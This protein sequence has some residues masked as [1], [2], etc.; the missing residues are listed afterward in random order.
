MFIKVSAGVI[1]DI[2]DI[3]MV[4][5]LAGGPEDVLTLVLKHNSR[6]IE[7]K[8]KTAAKVREA[9]GHGP[10]HGYELMDDDYECDCPRCDALRDD[11]IQ[12][13]RDFESRS[14]LIQ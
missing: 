13:L 8:G 3:Q 7:L 4:T 11:L 9:L 6:A 2:D 1:V 5:G 12:A 10:N 14:K